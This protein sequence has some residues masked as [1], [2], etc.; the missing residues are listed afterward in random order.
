MR[1]TA[2]TTIRAT[3]ATITQSGD[4]LLPKSFTSCVRK[5]PIS[6]VD[7][8]PIVKYARKR[9][10]PATNPVRGPSVMPTVA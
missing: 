7:P 2:S 4:A 5:K 3:I 1:L 6:I 8:A 10:H 9:A